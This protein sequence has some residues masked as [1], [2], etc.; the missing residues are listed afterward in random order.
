MTKTVEQ[1]VSSNASK[2]VKAD[3]KSAGIGFPGKMY[4]KV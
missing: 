4:N 3:P 2:I 1:N